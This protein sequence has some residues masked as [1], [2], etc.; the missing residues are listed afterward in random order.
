MRCSDESTLSEGKSRANRHDREPPRRRLYSGPATAPDGRLLSQVPGHDARTAA[1]SSVA[2]AGPAGASRAPNPSTAATAPPAAATPLTTPP[3][4]ATPLPRASASAPPAAATP[5]RRA[6]VSATTAAAT[7]VSRAS[8]SATRAVAAAGAAGRTATA[9]TAATSTTASAPPFAAAD[10]FSAVSIRAPASA[11][12]AA[13]G[14]APASL[15]L[16]AAA[17]AAASAAQSVETPE[18]M[19]GLVAGSGDVSL[20]L[21]SRWGVT[22]A[23]SRLF[24]V[25]DHKAESAATAVLDSDNKHSF[26]VV[27]ESDGNRDQKAADSWHYGGSPLQYR[28]FRWAGRQY[29]NY[30]VQLR[31]LRERPSDR[32]RVRPVDRLASVPSC[33]QIAIE[34]FESADSDRPIRTFKILGWEEETVLSLKAA[35][36]ARFRLHPRAFVLLIRVPYPIDGHTDLAP[37]GD[38]HVLRQCLPPRDPRPDRAETAPM[39]VTGA[40]PASVSR[41]AAAQHPSDEARM[42]MYGYPE[43][44]D[45]SDLSDYEHLLASSLLSTRSRLVDC[46][47]SN[48]EVATAP[49][50]NRE[51]QALREEVKTLRSSLDAQI[52]TSAMH[53]QLARTESDRSTR[54]QVAVEE[55]RSQLGDQ[56]RHIQRVRN[57]HQNEG[58]SALNASLTSETLNMLDD[59]PSNDAIVKQYEQLMV[60]DRASLVETLDRA[61][62]T[63]IKTDDYES[64][65]FCCHLVIE[66]QDRAGRM[67]QVCR[68]K[69]RDSM[70]RAV[71]GSDVNIS[72]VV[73]AATAP[74]GCDSLDA[75][76]AAFCRSN[77][78]AVTPA[79]PIWAAIAPT[80]PPSALIPGG[81]SDGQQAGFPT[82][83]PH[84]LISVCNG[85]SGGEKDASPRTLITRGSGEAVGPRPNP[86]DSP[87][88]ANHPATI[89]ARQSPPTAPQIDTP[90]AAPASTGSESAASSRISA[91]VDSKS[92][93]ST[94]AAASGD[95]VKGRSATS[96]AASV[97]GQSASSAAASEHEIKG[98]SVLLT[99]ASENGVKVRSASLTAPFAGAA[100]AAPAASTP[101]VPAVSSAE[102][103]PSD[104]T[105]HAPLRPASDRQVTA[106][107][108]GTGAEISLDI[109]TSSHV[110]ASA[111]GRGDAPNARDRLSSLL[112]A[113][114]DETGPVASAA[115]TNCAWELQ[116]R[117]SGHCPPNSHAATCPLNRNPVV[118]G[119]QH[120]RPH[121]LS[122]EPTN[123]S[124][125]STQSMQ[126][127]EAVGERLKKDAAEVAVGERLKKDAAEMRRAICTCGGTTADRDVEH[128]MTC[129]LRQVAQ[130]RPLETCARDRSPV[131]RALQFVS[132]AAR[133]SALIQKIDALSEKLTSLALKMQWTVPPMEFVG[134]SNG[135]P[136]N[137]HLHKLHYNCASALSIPGGGN[138]LRVAVCCYPA[139]RK[140][141]ASTADTRAE[142]VVLMHRF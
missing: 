7:P 127:Q 52:A 101:P 111:I 58:V 12:I 51:L 71:L 98:Q 141:G 120:S 21:R 60:V 22:S 113:L 32:G 76:L 80:T 105:L 44:D 62:E 133:R 48:P 9:V 108:T 140:R 15:A 45:S 63:Y 82:T 65:Q 3:A 97:K 77:H 110:D 84:A 131:W 56:E 53:Q 70:A 16:N 87:D 129:E 125:T 117:I 42:V 33:R 28:P 23:L 115:A 34:H 14:C 24:S 142:V 17:A 96:T 75:A 73:A 46:L 19:A 29:A 20:G 35:I 6:G 138:E 1:R 104:P 27:H 72:T 11:S 31:S 100:A 36:G 91:G 38:S 69:H 39:A 26:N 41:S 10:P 78:R 18:P 64:E 61:L 89:A 54:L 37:L 40:L 43:A 119:R 47:A 86:T 132:D 107:C 2:T 134:V 67:W 136:Y 74:A 8:T 135:S 57:D 92:R 99:A 5:S 94:M 68:E 139:L 106:T 49:S 81:G 122:G 126:S 114:G 123:S 109:S 30:A 102:A 128:G 116:C 85:G 4:A 95:N 103:Q 50:A 25:R 83:H 55:L 130:P 90:S 59:F 118:T 124:I 88:A 66:A 137:R 93:S 112:A 13:S 79:S 121:N